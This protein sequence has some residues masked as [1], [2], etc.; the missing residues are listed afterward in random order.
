MHGLRLRVDPGSLPA[1]EGCE[2][3]MEPLRNGR[4]R[5]YV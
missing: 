1:L 4:Y 3:Y 5:E 2:T